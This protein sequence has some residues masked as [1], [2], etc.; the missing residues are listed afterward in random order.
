ML[1]LLPLILP[2]LLWAM[3]KN[4]AQGLNAQQFKELFESLAGNIR[5]YAYYKTGNAPLADDLVQEAFTILWQKR[6]EVQL[7][8]VKNYLYTIA[9]NLV[10][11]QFRHQQVVYKF[12]SQLQVVEADPLT[13]EFLLEEEEVDRLLQDTLAQMKEEH[14]MV[15]LMNRIDGLSYAEIAQRLGISV[16]AV[17]KR[18]SKALSLLKAA[19]QKHSK[20]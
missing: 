10:A 16:K 4:N 3:L 6:H 20:H 11:K 15:F 2:Y 12:Q 7:A 9:N 19:L 18:M 8:T 14:R 5:N 1:L 13:P 17:E